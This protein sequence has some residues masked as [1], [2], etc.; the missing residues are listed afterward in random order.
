ML[1]IA[2]HIRILGTFHLVSL[3]CRYERN[4]LNELIFSL[5][6]QFFRGILFNC[7]DVRGKGDAR[8]ACPVHGRPLQLMGCTIGVHSTVGVGSEFWFEL[9]SVSAPL[10]AD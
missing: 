9:R 3:L 5:N 7:G 8:A 10:P 1:K 2:K 4:N 6:C